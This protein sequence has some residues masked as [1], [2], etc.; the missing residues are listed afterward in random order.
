MLKSGLRKWVILEIFS[1]YTGQKKEKK[2]NLPW[3][4][5]KEKKILFRIRLFSH[6][7]KSEQDTARHGLWSPVSFNG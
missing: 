6:S 3:I 4:V 2:S 1:E 7:C 5:K